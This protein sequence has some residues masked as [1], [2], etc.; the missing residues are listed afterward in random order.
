MGKEPMNALKEA[1]ADVHIIS[2]SSGKIKAWADGNWSNEYNVDKTLDEVSQSDYNALVLPGG[3]INPDVL[4]RNEKAVK[5]TKSFFE[6]HKKQNK[7]KKSTTQHS[8]TCPEISS[9]K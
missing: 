5:F 6:N 7:L 1:G 2:E 4:R 9:K 8:P 3:V